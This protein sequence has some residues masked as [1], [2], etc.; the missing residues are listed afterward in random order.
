MKN[1]K[2]RIHTE[3]GEKFVAIF[4]FQRQEKPELVFFSISSVKLFTQIMFTC[5]F[6]LV[7]KAIAS[8]LGK[9]IVP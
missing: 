4:V 1:E 7:H 8:R 3:R 5:R 2:L 9:P 6:D